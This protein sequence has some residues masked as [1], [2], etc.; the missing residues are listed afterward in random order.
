MLY[1][2]MTGAFAEMVVTE[3]SGQAEEVNS[4]VALVA[5]FLPLILP[6]I[7]I[8]FGFITRHMNLKKGYQGGFAW[9]FW[10][11]IIGIIVIA[12]RKPN[13]AQGLPDDGSTLTYDRS[14][15][16]IREIARLHAEGILSDEEFEQKKAE[17]LRRI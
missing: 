15:D 11:G 5:T 3:A 16:K 10:L 14:A 2:P 9:G 4:F 1:F 13:P 7:M 6:G 12:C 17:L 8:G